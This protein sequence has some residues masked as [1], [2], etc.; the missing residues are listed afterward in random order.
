MTVDFV[1]AESSVVSVARLGRPSIAHATAV[2][3]VMLAF[4]GA[5]AIAAA[6][7]ELAPCTDRTIVDPRAL[8]AEVDAV[9]SRGWAEAAGEREPDLNALGAPVFGRVRRARRDHRPPGPGRAA[10]GRAAG[11]GAARA[12]GRRRGR[13]A[14]ARR[15][16]A[17]PQLQGYGLWLTGCRSPVAK[18]S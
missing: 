11:G 10:D 2:G 13:A 1:A 7:A 17:P 5:G 8:A 4:G 16:T 15:L 14:R 9:R 18:R 3:K 12:A 6:G